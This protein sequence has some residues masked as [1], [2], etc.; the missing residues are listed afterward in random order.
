MFDR[1]SK[2]FAVA[3]LLAA[4]AA[5]PALAASDAPP[6]AQAERGGGDPVEARIKELH[7]RLHVTGAQTEQWEAIAA[8][9]RDNAKSIAALVADKR[10]R[11]NSMTATDDLHAYEEIAAAHAE[12]V[13]KLANAFDPFYAGMTADQKKVADDVF[14][15]HKQRAVKQAR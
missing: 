6:P 15:E 3:S 8:V 2:L 13:K 1:T 14:R 10:S 11:E 12:S 5:G 4:V 7:E 9:M